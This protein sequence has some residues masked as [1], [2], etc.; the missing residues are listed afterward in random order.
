MLAPRQPAAGVWSDRQG[1]HH[2]QCHR[3]GASIVRDAGIDGEAVLVREGKSGRRNMRYGR[4]IRPACADNTASADS[5]ALAA[6][7]VGQHQRQC[8]RRDPRLLAVAAVIQGDGNRRARHQSAAAGASQAFELP[9]QH[10][11]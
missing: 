6:L 3:A 4:D 11:A 5:Q 9:R 7:M 1:R 10:A 8:R 2:P